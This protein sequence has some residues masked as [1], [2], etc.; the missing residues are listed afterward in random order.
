[1][2][3]PAVDLHR[4]R[5][6]VGV[7]LRQAN[8]QAVPRCSGQMLQLH[9]ARQP[10]HVVVGRHAGKLAGVFPEVIGLQQGVGIF[11]GRHAEGSHEPEAARDHGSGLRIEQFLIAAT[12][13]GKDQRDELSRCGRLVGFLPAIGGGQITLGLFGQPR[14]HEIVADIQFL[15]WRPQPDDRNRVAANRHRIAPVMRPLGGNFRRAGM[16]VL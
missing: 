11:A 3:G 9:T 2:R 16:D 13:V 1:M 15:R 14:L 12:A 8:H 5:L 4:A 7:T 6:L 10:A